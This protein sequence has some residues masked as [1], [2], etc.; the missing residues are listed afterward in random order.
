LNEEKTI[1]LYSLQNSGGVGYSLIN[2]PELM[3]HVLRRLKA[4]VRLVVIIPWMLHGHILVHRGPDTN[5]GFPAPLTLLRTAQFYVM[6]N[7]ACRSFLTA[8]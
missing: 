1:S 4:F 2:L 6:F 8:L 3:A 7:L 5:Y